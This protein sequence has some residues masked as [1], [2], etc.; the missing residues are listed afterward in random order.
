M[1]RKKNNLTSRT[2]APERHRPHSWVKVL[3]WFYCP[4]C[5]ATSRLVHGRR[6]FLAADGR[7]LYSN[8]ELKQCKGGDA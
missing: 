1:T 3:A 4:R 2:P 5:Q 8:I 6:T 7:D